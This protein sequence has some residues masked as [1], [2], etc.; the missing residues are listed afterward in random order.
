MWNRASASLDEV[1]DKAVVAA[2]MRQR[3]FW[4]VAV[5]VVVISTVAQ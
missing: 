5:T 4:D 2:G 1:L 3:Y